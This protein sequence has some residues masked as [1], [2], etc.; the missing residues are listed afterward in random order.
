MSGVYKLYDKFPF[1]VLILDKKGDII[2]LNRKF[3]SLI[4]YD[5]PELKSWSSFKQI[6]F[7][8][9]EYHDKISNLL[10]EDISQ[11]RLND[12]ETSPRLTKV[13]CKGI[14]TRNLEISFALI[15]SNVLLTGYDVTQRESQKEELKDE[16]AFYEKVIQNFPGTF[17]MFDEK[18]KLKKWNRA[19][20]LL[21]GFESEEL[22]NSPANIFFTNLDTDITQEYYSQML[23]DGF[24]S[25]ETTCSTK[26]NRTI[27]VLFKAYLLK[28]KGNNFVVGSGLDITERVH[29]ENLLKERN[30]FI[31]K[32]L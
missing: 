13:L 28:Y 32:V 10:D 6:C 7:P 2:Y 11:C 4:G 24:I 31:E 25:I 26:E 12:I 21:S 20:E 9:K 18:L 5:I 30:E 27:H 17:F 14:I 8:N 1:P 19:L 29:A 16:V 23:S 15:E 3:K 22:N